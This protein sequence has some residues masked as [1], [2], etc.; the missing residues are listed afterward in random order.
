[1]QNGASGELTVSKSALF[2]DR[3]GVINLDFGYVHKASDFVFCDGIFDLVRTANQN[4]LTVIVVTNQAGIGRGYFSEE[5]FHELTEWMSGQFLNMGARI[6]HVYFSPYHPT[7]AIGAY[8]K[9][10]F[11]RKPNPGMLLQAMAEHDID[12]SQSL[13]VGDNISD[14]QAGLAAGVQLNLLLDNQGLHE[15]AD[16]PRTRRISRLIDTIPF[17]MGIVKDKGK[18]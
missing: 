11:S 9:D 7:E 8:R 12:L 2:L 15:N 10:D 4:H 17:L 6:D 18:V 16:M 13:L 14:M 5:T 3:D 1:L